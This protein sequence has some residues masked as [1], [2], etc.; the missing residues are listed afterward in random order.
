MGFCE[1]ILIR[2]KWPKMVRNGTER[3]FGLFKKI[4][5]S[6]LSGIGVKQKYL[7]SS[8]VLQKLHAWKKIWFVSYMAKNGSQPMRFQCSFVV[9]TSSL[10]WYLIWILE[11]R[12]A[13]MK[14]TRFI[15]RFSE[16]ILICANGSFWAQKLALRNFFLVFCIMKGANR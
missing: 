14:E 11:L 9:N 10:D 13:W 12:L 4:K 1:K 3:V 6:V 2:Q 15:N 7:R 8:N 5:S 16:K